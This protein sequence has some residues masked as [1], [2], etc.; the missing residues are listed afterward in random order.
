M[1]LNELLEIAEKERQRAASVRIRCCTAAGCASSGAE[2][3]KDRLEQSIKDA[4]LDNTVEVCSVGCMKFC[5]RGP[6]V[7]IDIPGVLYQQVSGDQVEAIV[8]ALKQNKAAESGATPLDREHPFF[9]LQQPIV[10]ENS[11]KINPERIE[12]YIAVGGYQNLYHV[13]HDMSPD[14]VVDEVT[15]SGLRGRGGGGYPTGLKWATVAK[16]PEGQKYVICNA[17]E[18]DPGAFMDRSVLESDPHRIIEGMAIAA[19]AIGANHGYIYVR[20]EYPL[21]IKRLETAI[22]QAKRLGLMGSQIFDSPFDFKIDIRV[23]A[24]AFVCGEE[25]ALM[26]SIEGGRGNPRP[27]P[28]YPAQSGLWH[29][30]TL[31][32]NVETFA[33]IPAIVREGAD[34]FASIGTE[35]SKGTKVFALTGKIRNTGLIEVP[36][37]IALREIVEKMGGGVPRGEVKAVQ[38]GG[39]SGGCI[40]AHLFDTPVEYD[41]LIQLGTMMG[42]GGMI[43]MDTETSMVDVAQFYMEFCRGESC[44]KCIPC[45]AGT[46]QMYQMLTKILRG[47]ATLI[48]LEQLER[49]CGMV[50]ATSLCG[51]GQTAPNPVLSTLRYFREEYLELLKDSPKAQ[52]VASR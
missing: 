6:L 14:E 16:M 39:P 22:K 41:S 51:L 12:E 29:S 21:A 47:E 27:R 9:T 52:G 37:G 30:P 18:G 40:P 35:K 23:G 49:V 25:T 24:G 38:T 8:D 17:D 46:V 15:R 50:K 11:G 34:W 45:R 28:P 36:M 1:D 3:I 19:Y 2:E 48:D 10:L 13:I 31:I 5:G 33:N 26:Q 42:S 43:V 44:G 20:A 4:G 32:N 7:E